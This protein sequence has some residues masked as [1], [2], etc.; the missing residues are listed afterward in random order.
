MCGTS[1]RPGQATTSWGV[2]VGQCIPGREYPRLT[3]R[4]GALCVLQETKVDGAQVQGTCL[5][6]SSVASACELASWSEC[7]T[8]LD[9][10]AQ[11]AD[12]SLTIDTV[13]HTS[14]ATPC[15]GL[16][17]VTL[18][19][20][21]AVVVRIQSGALRTLCAGMRVR[22]PHR[23]CRSTAPGLLS[24]STVTACGPNGGRVRYRAGLSGMVAQ[25]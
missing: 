20:T 23:T 14:M 4:A 17:S 24:C 13:G 10:T 7:A 22:Q 19:V 25:R 21:V 11:A 3:L 1:T 9:I 5:D 12:G 6:D 8:S 18:Q 2:L 16:A 15:T